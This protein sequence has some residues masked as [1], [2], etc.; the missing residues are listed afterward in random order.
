M[1]E[2]FHRPTARRAFLR[3]AVLGGATLLARPP[4]TWAQDSAS[5]RPEGLH[6]ALLSD[7]H[8]PADPLNEYRGFRPWDHLQAVVPQAAA[9]NPEWVII[10]GDAARLEGL[11][12]DYAALRALLEPLARQ[13]P[14]VI[15]LGNHDDRANFLKEFPD[16]AG[17]R[18]G[19]RG[20]HVTVI[21]HAVARI[22]V[23][24]SLLY[25]NQ[26]AGLLGREQRMWLAQHLPAM[27]D[28]PTVLMVH[29][30]LGDGD[31]DLLD[32]DRLF[33]LIRPHRHIRAI[34]YGHSHVWERQEREGVQLVN[35]PAVGYNFR[36][37][38][39]VGWVEAWFGKE[40]VRLKL[41]ALA[42]NRDRDGEVVEIAWT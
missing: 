1:P 37:Q 6:V 19:V 8:V 27:A 38:D 17:G 10:N 15:G 13:A 11:P 32:V 16:P 2:I 34:F 31:G 28:R 12:A 29:H 21:E 36:D 5:V 42:G 30:T 25:V 41:W 14:V 33:E 3:T 26:T 18:A 24:D 23:L 35:L 4:W 9:V 39:P 7:T 40:G 20:K 22:V